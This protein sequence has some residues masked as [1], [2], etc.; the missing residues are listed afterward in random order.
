[1][2]RKFLGGAWIALAA[3]AAVAGCSK[4]NG[5]GFFPANFGIDLSGQQNFPASAIADNN[6]APDGGAFSHNGQ[7]FAELVCK[8]N[9]SCTASISSSG[10]ST[11]QSSADDSAIVA[12][13]TTDNSGTGTNGAQRLW[14]SHWDGKSFTPPVEVTGDDRDELKGGSPVT[15]SGILMCPVNTKNYKNGAGAALDTVTA[16]A[17]NWVIVWD[18]VTARNTP[19]NTDTD[20]GP[21]ADTGNRGPHRT[22][23]YTLFAKDLRS[24]STATSSLLGTGKGAATTGTTPPT[25]AFGVREYRYGFLV[26]GVEILSPP[27]ATA[28]FVGGASELGKAS[29]TS[30]P[31]SSLGRAR[32]QRPAEDVIS[33]GMATDTLC[34][35]AKFCATN[36]TGEPRP[37][38]TGDFGSRLDRSTA[39][40]TNSFASGPN[41][42]AGPD[43]GQ[44]HKTQGAAGTARPTGASYSVGDDTSFL[45]VFYVQL[46]SSHAATGDT[47]TAPQDNSGATQGGE[48]YRFFSVVFDL[49][50]LS[51]GT[52][53]E[54]APPAARTNPLKAG[55]QPLPCF[56]VY[57]GHVFW[58]YLDASNAVDNSAVTGSGGLGYNTDVGQN[59]NLNG[60]HNVTFSSL[61]QAMAVT[62][63]ASTGDGKNNVLNSV[64]VTK[65]GGTVGK[66][67]LTVPNGPSQTTAPAN[68]ISALDEHVDFGKEK[69][70]CCIFGADENLN[71]TVAFVLVQANTINLG[72][73][74]EEVE[75][76]QVV[77]KVDGTFQTGVNPKVISV[78][79]KTDTVGHPS[80]S[81]PRD[82]ALRHQKFD[83]V[84]DYGCTMNRDGTVIFVAFRQLQGGT[85][86]VS[87]VLN[88]VAHRTDRTTTATAADTRAS[89]P[90]ALNKPAGHAIAKRGD[91]SATYVVEA[92]GVNAGERRFFT[93]DTGN[94]FEAASQNMVAHVANTQF[95]EDWKCQGC[96]G[97]GCGF[98]SS[99]LKTSYLWLLRDGTVDQVFVAQV[100]AV[101]TATPTVTV[102]NEQD[103]DT[104][105]VSALARPGVTTNG[106]ADPFSQD[107]LDDPFKPLI[108]TTYKFIPGSVNLD[109][110]FHACDCGADAAGV[111]GGVL[112]VYQKV[113][114]ATT[115]DGNFFDRQILATCFD[116]TAFTTRVVMSRGVREDNQTLSDV[117]QNGAALGQ[118][119]SY[120]AVTRNQWKTKLGAS[121]CTIIEAPGN[122]D[123][124]NKPSFSAD[125][126]VVNFN[127]PAGDSN[128]SSSVANSRTFKSSLKRESGG[129]ALSFGEQ[130]EPNT[131]SSI[132]GAKFLEPRRLD[133]NLGSDAE[134]QDCWKSGK[135]IIVLL[136]QD[137]H[138]WGSLTSDGL[139]WSQDSDGKPTPPLVD[140]NTSS[141]VRNYVSSCKAQ[142][143]DCADMKGSFLFFSK[144]DLGS[145]GG[146]TGDIRL[147][148]RIITAGN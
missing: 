115:T 110:D 123:F 64:D 20:K 40:G 10:G 127:A 116:G 126:I 39:L 31:N 53:A 148:V 96:L 83:S 21:R 108:A 132:T 50:T 57:N 25:S 61:T 1:M 86:D 34:G 114:D 146:V 97:Y 92:G 90:V 117:G 43:A 74:T 69:C 22:L 133:R 68:N 76:A 143:K 94:N 81:V 137:R 107:D 147:F 4:S 54:L 121:D 84:L 58:R 131:D 141:D 30:G 112:I 139:K 32:F 88:V 45:R 35:C 55:T 82:Q 122:S 33:Y 38:Q 36:G 79:D 118:G 129:T 59:N 144:D 91:I 62:T 8:F 71:D 142:G 75:L 134:F 46:V 29:V 111:G 16:N 72:E 15:V 9:Q 125:L 119:T 138:L 60:T 80:T 102:G 48:R 65:L 49:A 128:K 63:I 106:N 77:L 95:L 5:G 6:L 130:W 66:H 41:S 23:Y 28:P 7:N 24:K 100:T 52:P 135:T 140:N 27:G 136:K 101:I 37:I 120:A 98:Q 145:A 14:L 42:V 19:V 3:A 67:S 87:A 44:N 18:A 11:S 13:T 51:F 104:T 89:V 109:E 70:D 124:A 47:Y 78:H 17:G 12:F 56:N 73:K 113:V 105:L 85:L 26:K 99:V 103:V 93:G 2:F